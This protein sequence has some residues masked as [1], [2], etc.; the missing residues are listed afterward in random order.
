MNLS[1]FN[2]YFG[3]LNFFVPGPGGRKYLH[4]GPLDGNP[5][6]K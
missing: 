1:D 2:S 5:S 3:T 4:V 6:C